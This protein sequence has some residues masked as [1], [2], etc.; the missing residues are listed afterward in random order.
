MKAIPREARRVTYSTEIRSLKQR[1]N[2]IGQQ[3]AVVLGSVL[4]DGSLI[5]NWSRTNYR[6]RIRHSIKQQEYLL[7]KYR[8][9]KDW[10]LSVP[11]LYAKTKSLSFTTISHP[12]LTAIAKIFYR[13]NRKVVPKEIASFL[14]DPLALAI[15]FM[16]DGNAIKRN[17]KI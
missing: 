17:G 16:D 7:W 5:P 11:K 15:W 14:Q 2:L 6:L 13:K 4:G 12:E 9:L 3:R 1:L 10:V 8:I